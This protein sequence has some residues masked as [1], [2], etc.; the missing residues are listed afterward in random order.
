MAE[1]FFKLCGSS[2]I[3]W[4]H[5]E[6]FEARS[7]C[8]HSTEEGKVRLYFATELAKSLLSAKIV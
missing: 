2:K 6:I 8:C 4:L 5:E 7:R 1:R 3:S